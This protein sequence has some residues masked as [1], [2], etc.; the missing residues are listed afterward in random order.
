MIENSKLERTFL[1]IKPDAVQ[2]GKIGEIL[3][4]F[5]AKGLKIVALKM[6]QIKPEQAAR[7]YEC[8]KEKEFYNSLVDFICSSPAVAVVV[9][10]RNAITLCRR[11]M[12]GTKPLESLPGTIRGDGSLDVKHNLIHGSDSQASYEHEV[13]VY[14]TDEEMV[15]YN[16][17]LENWIYYS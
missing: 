10:G 16:L 5:E 11:I 3:G 17:E 6:L 7:Q 13:Q 4:R 2:R 14:F 12:G 1:L 15:K 9:E 8:H